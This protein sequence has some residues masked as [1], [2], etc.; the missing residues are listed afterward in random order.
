VITRWALRSSQRKARC[1]IEDVLQVVSV[2]LPSRRI[3]RKAR[4][5]SE[6]PRVER[7]PWPA[8]KRSD[9]GLIFT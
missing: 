5:G 9:C 3:H 1:A 4:A 7:S 6:N 8:L 2:G